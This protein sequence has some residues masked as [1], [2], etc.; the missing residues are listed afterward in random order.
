MSGRRCWDNA[1]GGMGAVIFASSAVGE[2]FQRERVVPFHLG[3]IVNA[4]QGEA[5]E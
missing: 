3:R 5:S 4:R 1:P 2:I